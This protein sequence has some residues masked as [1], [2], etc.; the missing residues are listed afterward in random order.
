MLTSAAATHLSTAPRGMS[1][2]TCITSEQLFEVSDS[3][4]PGLLELIC[5]P[6]GN[7]FRMPQCCGCVAP[8]VPNWLLGSG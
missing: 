2:V 3:E 4:E 6:G 5:W 7:P 8:A 1:T